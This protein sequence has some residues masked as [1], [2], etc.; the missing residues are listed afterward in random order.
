M[1]Q[2][3]IVRER[4]KHLGITME[5]SLYI[6]IHTWAFSMT[7][8]KKYLSSTKLPISN[9]K[10][11]SLWLYKVTFVFLFFVGFASQS[12]DDQVN[13]MGFRFLGGS[14]VTLL[15]SKTSRK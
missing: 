14:R 3:V 5:I 9:I 11:F 10:C 8:D 15:A 1:I 2:S 13:V 12:E 7:G 6:L 4:F